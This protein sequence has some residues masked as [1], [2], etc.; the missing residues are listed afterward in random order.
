[1]AKAPDECP[2]CGKTKGIR[3]ISHP[4]AAP[5][6]ERPEWHCSLCQYEWR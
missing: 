4:D 2:N 5:G 6:E 1:M 3:W